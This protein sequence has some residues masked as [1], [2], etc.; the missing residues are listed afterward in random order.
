MARRLL[1]AF[2]PDRFRVELQRPYWRHDRRR[3][4]L[5]AELAERLGVPCVATGN[6]HVHSRE[7]TPLQ[8]AMVAVRLGA[9]L[10]ETEPRRRGNSS[11]VLTP[12]ERMAERFRD[13]PEAVAES[14]RLAERLTFDLTEDLGYRYPG[15]ED[16]DAD[17][18]LAELC[19]GRSASATRAPARRGP[20]RGGAARDPPPG[21]VR[22]L[23]AAPR[24]AR[25]GARGRL[26]GARAGVG[27]A[28]AAARPRP[29][30][31]RVVDRLLPHRPLAHR[32]DRERALPGA[33][34]Q[35]GADR[36]ARHR[37]RLPA[38]H[39]RRADP[40]RARPLRARP[41]R[42]RGRLLD[43]PGALGGARLRQGARPAAGRDRAAGARGRP[44][45]GPQ[46]HRGRRAGARRGARRAGT[47]S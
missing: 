39:P 42:A 9:T 38:R 2:G 19:W 44:L 13:H 33:L 7:R 32:P 17:R 34:P 21:P 23:P 5:L 26:R 45:E 16:P 12:P 18:K 27:P 40:A 35:R 3:N 41:L 6:V 36:A 37:P 25:A 29:R 22:L 11:H 1:A 30:L 14:G 10:D 46:R 31:E 43:L 47:R 4:K 24:H 15:S 20:A 8:D 28:A